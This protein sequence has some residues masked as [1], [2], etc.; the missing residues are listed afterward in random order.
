MSAAKTLAN[1]NASSGASRF[2]PHLIGLTRIMTDW[3]RKTN[4]MPGPPHSVVV[5]ALQKPGPGDVTRPRVLWKS[6]MAVPSVTTPT[7]YRGVLYLLKEGGLLT[8]LDPDTGEVLKK[9]P[10]TWR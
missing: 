9:G 8:S 2:G 7:Q 6:G 1:E 4:G 3:S 10:T 5:V